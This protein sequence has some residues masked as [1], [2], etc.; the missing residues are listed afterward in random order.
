MGSVP[1]TT[2]MVRDPA[3]V[4]V[5]G[6]LTTYVELRLVPFRWPPEIDWLRFL[7]IPG[8]ALLVSTGAV[9]GFGEPWIDNSIVI[10]GS[11]LFWSLTTIALIGLG[12]AVHRRLSVKDAA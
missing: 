2:R 7:D 10:V 4:L 3:I 6:L 12:S 5:W 11:T 1:T 8:A 9:H